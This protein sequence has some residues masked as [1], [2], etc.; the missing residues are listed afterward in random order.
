M[1]TLFELENG[2]AVGPYHIPNELLKH[3][4]EKFIHQYASLINCSFELSKHVPSFSKGFLTPLQKPGKPEGPIK[5]LRPLCLLNGT[6]N[7]PFRDRLLNI[8]YT[9]PWQNTYKAGHSCV[10]IVWTQRILISVVKD[11]NFIRWVSGID[12]SSAFDNIRRSV[13]RML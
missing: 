8:H 2:K 4:P 9:G 11:G 5:S 10:Q 12:M 13:V 1:I 3:A 7:L 6:R